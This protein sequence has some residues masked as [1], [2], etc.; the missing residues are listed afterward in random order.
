[1]PLN[2][3]AAI[4]FDVDGTLMDDNRAVSLG[5]VSFHQRHGSKLDIS[6]DELAHRWM[7]LLHTHF[8]RYL[9]SEI[10]MREQ[11]RARIVD[12]FAASK[13]KL[14][15][16][17]ADDI[18]A[19]Y[20]S[21]YRASWCSYPDALS[22]LKALGGCVLAV[23]TNGNLAQQTQKLQAI[24]AASHFSGIFASSEIGF[25]KPAREA[26][27]HA[28]RQLSVPPQ[29][30]MYV[31]DNLET[32]ARGSAAAGL[33]GVWLDRTASGIDPGPDIRVIQSLSALPALIKSN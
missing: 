24:G 29:R 3:P 33:M 20:E 6:A 10:S 8:P 22:A 9:R 5:L 32:D 4:L 11:R 30:C 26:F 17:M 21:D 27:A 15:A 19:A 16:D 12:L 7:E 31:G 13:V 18:F 25:A 23:L 14:S 1:M 28:C 2:S